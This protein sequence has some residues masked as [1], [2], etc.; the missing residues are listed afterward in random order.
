[1]L[2]NESK[3]LIGKLPKEAMTKPINSPITKEEED[4][5]DRLLEKTDKNQKE[6]I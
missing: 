1:M 5:P 6:Q 3:I 4:M 2:D